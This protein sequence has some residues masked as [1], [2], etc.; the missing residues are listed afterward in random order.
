[1]RNNIINMEQNTE[2]EFFKAARPG[3]RR[4]VRGEGD[5]I[6]S[7]LKG[8]A[9]YGWYKTLRASESYR[10]TCRT[11][12]GGRLA[13]LYEDFGDVY[14]PWDMWVA[15]FGRKIFTERQALPKVEQLR[16]SDIE[17]LKVTQED[18]LLKVPLTISKV[19]LMRQIGKIIKEK[20]SGRK[21]DVFKR[22]TSKRPLLKSRVQ[23]P[24]VEILLEVNAA[25]AKHKDMPLWKVGELA[26][27]KIAYMSRVDDKHRILSIDEERRRMA[28]VT[29]GYL[30]KAR[31]L[32]DNAEN[33]LFPLTRKPTA[34]D[35]K[36]A[37]VT[38]PK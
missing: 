36:K 20:H 16:K 13:S 34:E 6:A 2:N 9:Y 12:G 3:Q 21:L 30:N 31:W 8:T 18:I 27:V 24:M 37:R 25:R 19:T 23:M 22:S 17:N 35:Y 28:I 11:K 32:I 1:M 15:R 4:F 7:R 5:E 26:G 33:G 38:P 29:S 10:E 14:M